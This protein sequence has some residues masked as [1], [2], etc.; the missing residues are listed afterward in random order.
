MKN[1]KNFNEP[2][3]PKVWLI[4]LVMVGVISLVTYLLQPA[5]VVDE[6]QSAP[7][8]VQIEVEPQ[9]KKIQTPPPVQI[10]ISSKDGV[11]RDRGASFK[12]VPTV[13]NTQQVF[14]S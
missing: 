2:I 6:I 5:K 8:D 14:L 11:I 9:E 7:Q 12:H 4:V 1:Q 13:S 3:R 10:N